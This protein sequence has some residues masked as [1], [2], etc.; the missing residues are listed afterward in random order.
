VI[1]ARSS[2]GEVGDCDAVTHSVTHFES[3]ATRAERP[4]LWDVYDSVLL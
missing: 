1:D 3:V 4:S 2:E